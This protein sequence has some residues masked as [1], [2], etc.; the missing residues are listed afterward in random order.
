MDDELIE[1]RTYWTF[2]E[3]NKRL[4]RKLKLLSFVDGKNKIEN[5]KEYFK[6]EK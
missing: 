5:G 2:E 6:Y 3:L 1:R 4:E